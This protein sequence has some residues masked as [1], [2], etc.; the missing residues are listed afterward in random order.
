MLELTLAIIKPHII[1]QP[2]TLQNIRNIIINSNFK[3]VKSQQF[4]L[5][6]NQAELFYDEHKTKFFFNRL[7]T[8]MTRYF[9]FSLRSIIINLISCQTFDAFLNIIAV[10]RNFTSLQKPTPSR[11]GG[12]LWARQKYSERNSTN[13]TQ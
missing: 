6:K 1:K 2:H 12:R 5:T 3:V 4:C 13:L 7:V 11:N 10:L 9:I 8:F